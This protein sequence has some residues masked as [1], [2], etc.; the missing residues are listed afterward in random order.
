MRILF[1]LMFFAISNLIAQFE[2]EGAFPH[3]NFTRPVDLQN[4][5]DQ[6]DR[7]FV[8][9][10]RGIVYVFPN[11]SS[12][13]D[14]EIFIDLQD[15]VNDIGNEEGLLGL[16]F[17]PDYAENGFFYV[18]YTASSPRRTVIA[19]YQVSENDPDKADPTSEFVL[20]EFNQPE[21]NHNGGQLSFGPDG[22]LYIATGDGGGGGD[23][24]GEIGNGQD[25]TTLLGNILRINVNSMD[26]GL[27]YA[28]PDDNPFVQNQ[29]GYWEE[30][31]AY[32]LRNPWRM[33]FDSE[34]GRLWAGDVGQGDY[35]E[36]DII[37]SGNNYGWRIMEGFHCYNPSEECDQTGL[38]LPIWEYSHEIGYSIT[39]G[40]VYR[41]SDVP[42]LTGKYIY[43]DYVTRWIWALSYDGINPAENDTVLQSPYSISSFGL[44]ENSELYICT[45]NGSSSQIYK[46]KPTVT[47]TISEE[48]NNIVSK[49][50]FGNNYPNPFNPGTTIPYYLKSDANV[51]ISVFNVKGQLIKN[52]INGKHQA[53]YYSVYWDGKNSDA[54]VQ[55]SG[56]YFCRMKIDNKVVNTK[57][58]V[59][60][61]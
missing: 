17:H 60:I 13:S 3:L 23:N 48:K 22:Y 1:I 9:E 50:Y 42:E 31:F 6:S 49:Y 52:L 59:L 37:E 16:A 35:E 58:L 5:G 39:G 56:I 7:I 45:F 43:G 32:G 20:L 12:V 21:S 55:T 2:I 61:K 24:H 18:N 29:S 36:I 57:G 54:I 40:Y 38:T 27:N 19:R 30:I 8:V 41:G 25:R 14:A 15:S 11:D 51:E 26:N 53:G 47:S 44:D 4:A 33:S 46:F 34:T 28:I 10:Q